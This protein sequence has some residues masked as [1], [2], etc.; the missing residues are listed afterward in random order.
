MDPQKFKEEGNEHF[1]NEDFDEAITCYTKALKFS[2][3]SKNDKDCA[4]YLKNRS[5]CKL[6]VENYEGAL[7]DAVDSL[8]LY[9]N[10][11][12]ALFRQVQAEEALEKIEDAAQN[13]AKLIQMDPRN[14]TFQQTMERLRERVYEKAKEQRDMNKQMENMLNIIDDEEG[15][16]VQKR[17]NAANNILVLAREEAT[18]NQLCAKGG[19]AKLKD[20]IEDDDREV[21]LSAVRALGSLV[22]D[23]TQTRTL[24]VFR[25]IGLVLICKALAS[26]D[27]EISV[28]ACILYT[29]MLRHLS[30][31][32]RLTA[33]RRNLERYVTIENGKIV[34]EM[35]MALCQMLDDK[36]VA[37]NAR[38][39]VVEVIH[40]NFD[41]FR[42]VGW[43]YDFLRWGLRK[44]LRAGS[45]R[46]EMNS[47][48]VTDNTRMHVSHCLQAVYEEMISDSEREEYQDKVKE[49][50]NDML[51][52]EN[53]ACKTRAC[54]AL[55]T[56]LEGPIDVG[57]AVL[58]RPGII[59][60]MMVLAQSEDKLQQLIAVEAIASSATKQTAAKSII[61]L[62]MGVLKELYK[63]KHPD[64]K[65][66][67]LVGLCKCASSG[68]QDA[69]QVYM[70]DQ[71][72]QQLMK[73]TR[74]FLLNPT[75]DYDQ[76]RWAAEGLACLTLKADIKEEIIDDD[77]VIESLFEIAKNTKRLGQ[78][79]VS[80][81]LVNLTNTYFNKDD[82]KE[83]CREE[84]EKVARFAKHH[85]PEQHEGD[86]AKYV[87]DR[88]NTLMQYHVAT[89]LNVIASS[90]SKKVQENCSRIYEAITRDKDHRG[91]VVAAGG[92]RT[93]IDLGNNGN[94]ECKKRAQQSLS[95]IAISMDPNIAFS[96]Q[97][98]CDAVRPVL[99][100]LEYDKTGMETF[101]GLLALTNLASM[102]D[103]VRKRIY[104]DK[105]FGS[106]ETLM[107]DQDH[108]MLRR[109]ATEVINN[110]VMS[111][112]VAKRFETDVTERMK[113]L[114]L[115]CEEDD[116][117]L[118]RAASGSLAHLTMHENNCRRIMTVKQWYETFRNLCMDANVELQS[119]GVYII[120]NM[121]ESCEE[122]AQRICYG[123]MM[124]ILMAIT[125]MDEDPTRAS[126]LQFAERALEAAR[127]WGVI[128]P[129]D[130]GSA[131]SSSTPAPGSSPEN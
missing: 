58:G 116:F 91:P 117:E 13:M 69:S 92:V 131:A 22:R 99:A 54:V 106:I 26:P 44:M 121:M 11:P 113:L 124:E 122:A 108:P 78:Y 42:G 55:T 64:I 123:D 10:D 101:E 84:L 68:G 66:R 77:E 29:Q 98:A 15:G 76:R 93:L 39:N 52:D 112:D 34:N 94:D 25:D 85:V 127:E 74:K 80:T 30:G 97:R 104:A 107:F 72:Y 89:V 63:S 79:A 87:E 28:S 102:G 41:R 119:R 88:I 36:R 4:I 14:K 57:N 21:R 19:V 16:D 82:E 47:M 73:V 130:G 45:Y 100:L 18:A 43:T 125:K 12:K 49:F 83:L 81:V 86:K 6:K 20:M 8:S 118:V 126:V 109:A 50:M 48:P 120:A 9:P 61:N 110:L 75:K 56:L 96:G 67:A 114:I 53:I 33:N 46:P 128:K 129:I 35:M 65:V 37:A 62:G 32:F 105:G 51:T 2:D 3:R 7:A 24:L 60:L 103:A 17:R 38:D 1:K 90:E 59:E 95:R 5:A 70:A 111:E 115:Y 40:K 31:C 71:S 27:D 23:D